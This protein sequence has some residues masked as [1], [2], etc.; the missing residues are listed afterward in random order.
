MARYPAVERA[1]VTT[2][3]DNAGRDNAGKFTRTL[4]GAERDAR[5][6]EM[7]SRGASYQQISDSLGYGGRGNAYRAVQA[8]LAEI[9][10]ESAEELR[11]IQLQQLDQLTA[12]ALAVLEA[13]QPMVTQSGRIVVDDDGQVLPDLTIRAQA[14]TI[15][16][17]VHD[18]RAKLMGLDAPVKAEVITL[19]YLNARIAELSADI[20]RRAG[21]FEDDRASGVG[22]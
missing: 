5:A 17:R 21:A 7:K 4:E 10:L 15:L 19:D 22:G 2:T 6:C 14:L 18:R 16:I 12:E 9:P 11:R 1:P 3:R 13:G 8:A 20:A